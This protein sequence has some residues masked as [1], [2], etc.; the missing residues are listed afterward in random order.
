[1]NMNEKWFSKKLRS[2][3]S[4]IHLRTFEASRLPDVP[5]LH[6]IV[7][8]GLEFWIELKCVRSHDCLIPFRKG[9]PEWIENYMHQGGIVFILVI[10]QRANVAQLLVLDSPDDIRKIA[11]MKLRVAFYNFGHYTFRLSESACGGVERGLLVSLLRYFPTD[12]TQGEFL[13]AILAQS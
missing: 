6:A 10:D 7:A 12:S 8:R 1:M 2:V 5:D 3:F 9:Q 11:Q 4:I 13:K